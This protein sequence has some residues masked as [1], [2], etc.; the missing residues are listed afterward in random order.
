MGEIVIYRSIIFKIRRQTCQT[1]MKAVA[2]RS[3]TKGA[4]GAEAKNNIIYF[5]AVHEQSFVSS[6]QKQNKD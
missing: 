4:Q 6:I 2:Q 3:I 1:S 5:S